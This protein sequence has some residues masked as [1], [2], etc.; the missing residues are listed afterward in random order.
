MNRRAFL[1]LAAASTVVAPS[2]EGFA[3]TKPVAGGIH[4]PDNTF[5]AGLPHLLDLATLPGLG[6]AIVRPLNQSLQDDAL[7][8]KWGDRVTARHVLSPSTG[9][10][11]GRSQD[12]QKLTPAF[13]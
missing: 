8:G 9:L 1:H 5:V 13:E 10:P 7:T 12:S 2:L 4:P 6:M 11:N 3:A